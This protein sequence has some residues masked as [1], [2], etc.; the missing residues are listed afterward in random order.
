M[1]L[2]SKSN[3][4]NTACI[5]V[6]TVHNARA[7]NVTLVRHVFYKIF[8]VAPCKGIYHRPVRVACTGMDNHA[9]GL[10]YDKH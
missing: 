7:G 3:Y 10:V 1:G 4:Q 8:P 2:W 9:L 5:L 6:Q